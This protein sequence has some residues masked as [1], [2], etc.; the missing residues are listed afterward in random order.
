[1]PHVSKNSPEFFHDFWCATKPYSLKIQSVLLCFLL[2]SI[3]LLSLCFSFL[4]P[5]F[6]LLF[7][8]VPFFHSTPCTFFH[9]TP[10]TNFYPSIPTL[11]PSCTP[12]Y[13]KQYN[14]GIMRRR[15]FHRVPHPSKPPC[16]K[17]QPSSPT[18]SLSCT[19]PQ[20]RAVQRPNHATPILS[21]CSPSPKTPE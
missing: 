14:D 20:V 5:S 18:L 9:F 15:P 6:L 7:L 3:P 21:S 2:P 17:F 13:F 1:M 19:P 10:C 4:S 8:P 16:T 12:L 11:N